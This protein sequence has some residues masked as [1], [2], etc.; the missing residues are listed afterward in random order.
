MG[1]FTA[2]SSLFGSVTKG[3]TD[4]VSGAASAVGG[5]V[6]TITGGTQSTTAA[7][8][9]HA[10]GTVA[11]GATN[12]VSGTVAAAG[13]GQGSQAGTTSANPLSAVTHLAESVAE[14]AVHA[15][16]GAASS[17][18]GAIAPIVQGGVSGLA[19]TATNLLGSIAGEVSNAVSHPVDTAQHA[20]KFLG[21]G[22]TNGL[23]GINAFGSLLGGSSEQGVIPDTRGTMGPLPINLSYTD[24][25]LT[26][27]AE[28]PV[29]QLLTSALALTPLVP[30]V[31]LLAPLNLG[32]V[33][34]VGSVNGEGI[35]AKFYGIAG[36]KYDLGIGNVGATL[37][38]GNYT[39][40][41][42]L[43]WNDT[44]LSDLPLVGNVLGHVPVIGELSLP[45]PSLDL[46][47][48]SK[49]YAQGSAA[50]HLNGVALGPNAQ[51]EV[52]HDLDNDL[53]IIGKLVGV[54]GQAVL[55]AAEQAFGTTAEQVLTKAI[56]ENA[57]HALESAG[58]F[59]VGLLG[60]AEHPA[61]TAPA[62]QLVGSEAAVEHPLAA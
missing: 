4:A 28:A 18:V 23:L 9:P 11:E 24:H 53:A 59:V 13:N 37:E 33:G 42:L 7:T 31:P 17:A 58:S 15:V 16:T 2:A 45:V 51:V 3:V 52:V 60:G 29:T 55:H 43:S 50:A 48:D 38:A 5:V 46:G 34:V 47:F 57:Y 62:I 20:V 44:K 25:G 30:L 26:F 54:S 14:G 32:G 56:G 39:E 41:K 19:S 1:L 21:I 61:A 49:L 27:G 12:A 6:G 8:A 40:L 36:P 35:T 22:D 10:A